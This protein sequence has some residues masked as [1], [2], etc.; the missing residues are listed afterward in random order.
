MGCSLLVEVGW[1]QYGRV[2]FRYQATCRR[3]GHS[4][5]TQKLDC[6]MWEVYLPRYLVIMIHE[7]HMPSKS[8]GNPTDT[9]FLFYSN[10]HTPSPLSKTQ[11]YS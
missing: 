1:T 6:G 8:S 11:L 5:E 3:N 9:M 10:V 7:L 2:R 4:L